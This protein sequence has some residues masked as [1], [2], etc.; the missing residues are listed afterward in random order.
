MYEGVRSSPFATPTR[1]GASERARRVVQN[2]L[3]SAPNR[4]VDEG[5]DA[6]PSSLGPNRTLGH[7]G[8]LST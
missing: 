8:F 1:R 6:T 7:I 3:Y 5:V 4:L 2:A